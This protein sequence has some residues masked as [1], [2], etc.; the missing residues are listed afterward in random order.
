MDKNTFRLVTYGLY[1]VSSRVSDALNGQIANTVFQ[2]SSQPPAFAVC[3]NRENLTHSFI[4]ASRTFSV[5]ILSKETPLEFIGRF[6]FRSGREFKKFE[7]INYKFGE[8]GTPIVL[9]YAIGYIECE[10]EREV[11]VYTHTIFVGRVVSAEVLKD[12][13]PLTYA[14]Y[15]NVKGGKTQARAPTK[16]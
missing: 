4:K 16:I 8:R 13:E 3:I 14:Y 7:N 11:D 12:E 5:S 15:Q 6:G 1:V 2:V 9:D 10:L